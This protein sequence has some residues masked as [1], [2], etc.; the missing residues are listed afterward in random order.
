MSDGE[1]AFEDAFAVGRANQVTIELARRHCLNMTFTAWGGSGQG[2]AEATSG[3]PIG[4]RQVSCRWPAATRR[5]QL[6]DVDSDARKPPPRGVRASLRQ[7]QRTAT[8]W[9]CGPR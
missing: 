3:L 6:S 9:A 7:V 2:L 5:I 1:Q 8:R 4:R